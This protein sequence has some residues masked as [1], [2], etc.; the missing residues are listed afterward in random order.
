MSGTAADVSCVVFHDECPGLGA[1]LCGDELFVVVVVEITS[2]SPIWVEVS[3]GGYLPHTFL[4]I[5]SLVSC[6]SFLSYFLYLSNLSKPGI[7]LS[8][9]CSPQCTPKLPNGEP[10]D[11]TQKGRAIAKA[12]AKWSDYQILSGDAFVVLIFMVEFVSLIPKSNNR[13][14]TY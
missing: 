14:R 3:M 8:I 11:A 7:S 5:G 12:P 1:T 13:P 4:H 6:H 9:W 10:Q 2:M